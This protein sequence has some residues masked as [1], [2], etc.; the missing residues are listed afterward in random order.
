MEEVSTVVVI[1]LLDAHGD[2]H[3]LRLSVRD[4]ARRQDQ[5]AAEPPGSRRP[6]RR[7]T[8]PASRLHEIAGTI[9]LHTHP[10]PSIGTAKHTRVVLRVVR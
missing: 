4:A 7:P 9:V 6:E 5:A 2:L 3:V 10:Q 8:L 1:D